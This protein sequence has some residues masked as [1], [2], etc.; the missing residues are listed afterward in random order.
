MTNI[1]IQPAEIDVDRVGDLVILDVSSVF[2]GETDFALST[3]DAIRLAIRL[4][5]AVGRSLD[6][7]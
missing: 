7:V 6:I 2:V 1:D 5:A 4:M 3:D